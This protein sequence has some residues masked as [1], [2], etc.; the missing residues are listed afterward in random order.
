MEIVR[1]V[2]LCVNLRRE[3]VERPD[4]MSAREKIVGEMGTNETRATGNQ[5]AHGILRINVSR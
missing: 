4:M 3:I 5:D 1:T 2:G